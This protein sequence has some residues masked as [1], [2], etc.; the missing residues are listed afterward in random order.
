MNYIS[1]SDSSAS[2]LAFIKISN[3]FTLPNEWNDL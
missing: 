3:L 2:S 1:N